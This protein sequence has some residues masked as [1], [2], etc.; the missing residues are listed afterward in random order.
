M[1]YEL[2]DQLLILPRARFY[3]KVGQTWYFLSIRRDWPRETGMYH[4]CSVVWGLPPPNRI[5]I[6][7]SGYK[8]VV[9]I[10]YPIHIAVHMHM[11]SCEFIAECC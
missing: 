7:G 6:A 8:F 11:T 4:E 10:P 1:P 3:Q 9:G 5:E 2:S